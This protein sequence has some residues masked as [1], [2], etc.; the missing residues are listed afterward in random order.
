VV[1]GNIE[2]GRCGFRRTKAHLPV[3]S[4]Q[5]RSREKRLPGNRGADRNE[6]SIG[7]GLVTVMLNDYYVNKYFFLV[8]LDEGVL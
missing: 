2:A 5:P 1:S 3:A 6:F 8:V 4:G 7:V